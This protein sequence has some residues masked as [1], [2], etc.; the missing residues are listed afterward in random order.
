M[1]FSPEIILKKWRHLFQTL[2]PLR[3]WR[4]LWT[5]PNWLFL[6]LIFINGT[7]IINFVKPSSCQKANNTK[8]VAT[9]YWSS[10]KT[11]LN[12]YS[13]HRRRNLSS[14]LRR[15]RKRIDLLETLISKVW[16][17]AVRP[18]VYWCLAVRLQ[19]YWCKTVEG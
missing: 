12:P 7:I 14:P 1:K 6:K 3:W 8:K 17:I 13:R 16:C 11:S 15:I 2:S 9:I 19:V 5:L 4:H 10:L 18:Q